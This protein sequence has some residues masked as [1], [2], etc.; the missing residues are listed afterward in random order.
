MFVIR[1]KAEPAGAP[2]SLFGV[3]RSKILHHARILVR[4]D[5]ALLD[6]L[7]FKTGTSSG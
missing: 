2:P 3:I 4:Q 1:M 5:V 7:A 6:R